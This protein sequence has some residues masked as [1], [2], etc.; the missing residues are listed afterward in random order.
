M[1]YSASS[2]RK[3]V[4][5]GGS[6][7]YK[8]W[9]ENEK[10]FRGDKSYLGDKSMMGLPGRAHI[11]KILTSSSRSS[12]VQ[13]ARIHQGAFRMNRRNQIATVTAA[14][15]TGEDRMA[16]GMPDYRLDHAVTRRQKI[17]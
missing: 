12:S 16:V 11:S 1:R 10:Q 7:T 6:R 15:R 2:P 13:T 8:S 5:D 9:E 4:G 14:I 17:S 3:E